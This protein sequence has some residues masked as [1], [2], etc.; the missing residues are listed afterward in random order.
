MPELGCNAGEG[1]TFHLEVGDF[2]AFILEILEFFEHVGHC[3]TL[4]DHPPLR[5]VE[6]GS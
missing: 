4:T 3:E 6:S 2:P 5:A 1:G